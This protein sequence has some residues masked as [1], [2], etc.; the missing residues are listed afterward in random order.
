M[1]GDPAFAL[2]PFV[3]QIA[4]GKIGWLT[5]AFTVALVVSQVVILYSATRRDI[6]QIL[7]MGQ[8]E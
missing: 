1:S 3:R 8:R 5:L 7:R 2:P 6:F 4:W